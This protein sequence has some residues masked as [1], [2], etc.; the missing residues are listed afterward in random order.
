MC[1]SQAATSDGDPVVVR[2]S[3]RAVR[4][5][6][7]TDRKKRPNRKR[8]PPPTSAMMQLRPRPNINVARPTYPTFALLPGN[9]NGMKIHPQPRS[10]LSM[11][12]TKVKSNFI[13]AHFKP[14]FSNAFHR[15]LVPRR[16]TQALSNFPAPNAVSCL[17]P[18]RFD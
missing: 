4:Y 13:G 15:W 2:S 5:A 18:L 17:M 8:R 11:I 3:A 7:Y 16:K 1:G 14:I 10:L 6:K 12:R 9:S